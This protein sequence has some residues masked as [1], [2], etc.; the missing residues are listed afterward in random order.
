[1][2]K[3]KFLVVDENG[4][5]NRILTNPSK[6]MAENFT[7]I[8]VDQKVEALLKQ[9]CSILDLTIRN[10]DIIIEPSESIIEKGITNLPSKYK[11]DDTEI[12][13]KI[14]D[15]EISLGLFDFEIR[16]KCRQFSNEVEAEFKKIDKSIS[17]LYKESKIQTENLNERIAYSEKRISALDDWYKEEIKDVNTLFSN[18]QDKYV[19]LSTESLDNIQKINL[20][21]EKNNLL[22]D[23]LT[24]LAEEFRKH[25]DE[26]AKSN[27]KLILCFSLALLISTIIGIIF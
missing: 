13:G 5:V 20:L 12:L 11:Y 27:N 23:S 24:K 8:P 10:G 26:P 22:Q 21:E 18:I 17:T 19:G 14:N 1:M 2:A 16:G 15:L 6:E 25:K 9:G 4:R 3:E 7:L